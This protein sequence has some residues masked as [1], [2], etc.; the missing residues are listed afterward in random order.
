VVIEGPD[1]AGKSTQLKLLAKGLAA[2]GVRSAALRE[3]G[4]TPAGEAIRRLLLK[5]G[6]IRLT[7]LAEAF[8]FEAARAQLVHDVV[9]PTLARGAWVLT[10]RYW[11]S[12]LIY[13]GYAG[14]VDPRA[15]AWMSDLATGRLKPDLYIV[16]GVPPEVGQKRRRRRQRATDRMES[17][18]PG[19]LE[20]VSNAY[21][22]LARRARGD[23]KFID[24]RASIAEVQ[25]RIWAYVE[26]L[27]P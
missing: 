3:P 18:G 23:L 22:R 5:R 8:L 10:D 21:R 14:G 17:R 6:A 2:R 13:Q 27:L 16:L 1:G 15:I 19:F 9:R 11:L 20:A 24:G 25:R 4:G 26:P 7:P 12:T